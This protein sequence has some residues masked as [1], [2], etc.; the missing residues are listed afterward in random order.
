MALTNSEQ[1]IP[2]FDTDKRCQLVVA[3][4]NETHDKVDK[5]KCF[6]ELPIKKIQI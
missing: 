2:Y 3:F 5:L 4:L 1:T 6:I